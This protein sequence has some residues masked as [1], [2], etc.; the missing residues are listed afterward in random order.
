MNCPMSTIYTVEYFLE[1]IIS[2]YR[3][4]RDN[5]LSENSGILRPGSVNQY[6]QNTRGVVYLSN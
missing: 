6:I 1:V 3:F 2:S 5:F 4:K